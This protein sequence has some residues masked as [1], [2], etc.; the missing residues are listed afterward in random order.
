[1][2]R[3]IKIF[4]VTFLVSMLMFSSCS[5]AAEIIFNPSGTTASVGDTIVVR[6]LL[7]TQNDSIN[8][9]DLGVLYPGILSVKQISKAGSF[10]QIWVR[11]P[12]YTNNAV[13]LSGGTPGGTTSGS[14]IIATITFEAKSAGDGSL[15]L[16]PA[17]AV[18][19]N[20]G[21]G[22]GAVVGLRTPEIHIIPRKAGVAP[23]II[24]QSLPATAKKDHSKPLSFDPMIGSDA[25]LFGGKYFVSFFSTDSGSGIE[26]YEIKEGNNPY[27]L[28]RSPFLLSDQTLHSVIHVRAYD[29]A[30][31]Y[32][33]E[34]YPGIVKRLWWWITDHVPGFHS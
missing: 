1:M 5:Q 31:N 28:G 21:S 32:R 20:D 14:A 18:L 23:K 8:A 34:T 19:L 15:G 25:R 24:E 2:D 16:S 33:E 6:V 3:I 12:S 30:G 29:V 10:V 7:D 26:R 27:V 22:T 13:F 17:S 11:E 9:I 4:S